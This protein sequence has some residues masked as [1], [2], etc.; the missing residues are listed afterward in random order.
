MQKAIC[1]TGVCRS[2]C[3]HCTAFESHPKLN[4]EQIETA[5]HSNT[6][7]IALKNRNRRIRNKCPILLLFF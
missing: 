3:A 2:R 4:L 5:Q 1:R 6:V 7:I